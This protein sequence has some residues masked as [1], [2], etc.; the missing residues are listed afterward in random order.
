[1]KAYLVSQ[2]F[3]SIAI[4]AG[5]NRT[6]KN[7]A[8]LD[9]FPPALLSLV[10]PLLRGACHPDYGEG[11]P[12]RTEERA[13]RRPMRAWVGAVTT[14]PLHAPPTAHKHDGHKRIPQRHLKD[15]WNI[16]VKLNFRSAVR[17]KWDHWDGVR[18]RRRRLSH[19]HQQL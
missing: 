2:H 6:L 13:E 14:C 1:M 15:T 7:R 11:D 16:R 8:Q 12:P 9:S 18:R 3:S 4:L 5:L 17:T 19:H 10:P